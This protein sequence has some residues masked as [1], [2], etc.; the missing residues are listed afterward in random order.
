[1]SV[2]IKF[3]TEL[4]QNYKQAEVVAPEAKFEALQTSEG[5]SLFFSI[6]MDNIFYLTREIVEH[7]TGWERTD[8]SSALSQFHN[9]LPVTAKTFAVSQ[10]N[11]SQNVDIALAVT[12][13]GKDYL[14]LAQNNSNS[15]ISWSSLG[16]NWL[17]MPFDDQNHSY[18][19]IDIVDIYIAQAHN[20][21]YIV[22]DIIKNP[23]DGQKFV[24]RYYIDP[25]KQIT[26]HIWNPHDLPANIEPDQISSC[27]GRRAKERVDGIY[28]FG[29]INNKLELFY[30]P[31]Y[32]PFNPRTPANPVRLGI[33]ASASAIAAASALDE[34]YTDLFIAGNKAL[35]Y[36]PYNQ[37]Q[38]GQNAIKVFENEIFLD[39]QKLFVH[40]TTSKVI[41]W[42]LN[43]AQEIFYT[44]CN[45]TEIQNSSAWSYPLALLNGVE[46][47]ATYV[48]CVND[49]NTF[50]AHVGNNQLKKAVQ[51]P[52]TTIWKYRDILLPPLKA[53][54]TESLR[55]NS[56][57]TRIHIT[58]DKNTPLSGVKIKLGSLDRCS[59]Y[60]NNRYY[61]LDKEPIEITSDSTGGI[62]IVEKVDNLRGSC[63]KIFTD[64]G[65]IISIN[66]M[67]KSR[68]KV[69]QLNSVEKLTN[70]AIE[71]GT[72]GS[73]SKPLISPSTSAA[74]KQAIVD[75]I[76]QIMTVSQSLPDDGSVKS[77]KNAATRATF[78]LSAV[79]QNQVF[80]LAMPSNSSISYVGTD[81]IALH[82][83]SFATSNGFYDFT[84]TI[85]VIAGDIISF[86]ES[87]GKEIFHV[88]VVKAKEAWHFI[89][90]VGEK[91]YR[92]AL[93]CAE[94]VIHGIEIIFKGINTFIGDLINYV[95]FLFNWEDFVRTKDVFKKLFLLYFN[96]VLDDVENLKIDFNK[97][98]TEAKNT[99]DDWAGIK[100]D[101][102]K[103]SVVNS[104]HPLGYLRTITDVGGV[105]TSPGMFLFQHFVDNAPSNKGS[106]NAAI[107][108][109]DDLLNRT[110]QA[111]EDEENV[112]IDAVNRIRSELI[113]NLQYESLSFGDVLT[114]LT[115]IIVDAILYS[116]EDLV[117]L[118]IDVF[119]TIS[120]A[121]VEALDT[122]I[123]I[124]VVS[125]ILEDIGIKISFSMLDVVVMIGAIP[126]TLVYM[127]IKNMA[128]FSSGDGFSDEILAAKDIYS[129][130]A[131]FAGANE[132]GHNS[133]RSVAPY[134]AAMSN[135]MQPLMAMSLALSEDHGKQQ[136][137]LVPINLP[138]VARDSIFL[139]GNLL[140]GVVTLCTSVLSVADALS[141]EGNS[142]FETAV[143]VSAAVGA[144]SAGL[145]TVFA[146][147]YPIQNNV[148]SMLSRTTTGATLLG[149]VTFYFAPKAVAKKRGITDAVDIQSLKTK[150]KKIGTGFD[151]VIALFALVPTCYH[152]YE[153][154][155]YQKSRDCTEAILY[156]TSNVCNYL[157]RV[158]AFV[159]QMDKE[160]DSKVIFVGTMGTLIALCG[161]LQIAESIIEA[162]GG[163]KVQT[164]P[165]LLA[166]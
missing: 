61:V 16:L 17:I 136:S 97:L 23:D 145:S 7:S 132:G 4:M 120:R 131:A 54:D 42:G 79:P 90:K 36:L 49:G 80:P 87:T 127:G 27:L 133:I 22:V 2:K 57:T 147:P 166:L 84:S 141:D 30:T 26:G 29:D 118:L 123:W 38:D 83:D 35:Y 58:D 64:D 73:T 48:N 143:G 125:D 28:T 50:F 70:A 18:S 12:V 102:W 13:D 45:K 129:L 128:P 150:F 63:F 156:E 40:T 88:F 85:E 72:I 144:I 152:F 165:K 19:R 108:V 37:Q 163:L 149:K 159:V 106:S 162:T 124:P 68:K 113:D 33:P 52:E 121:V 32:N 96:H 81:A 24:F 14:Y 92:F 112:V 67:E 65:K 39:V 109:L 161:G 53:Q 93:D 1:M 105:F 114:K 6:G 75:S 117:D 34:N 15:D 103:P 154:S 119:V 3:S 98:I 160:P 74:D 76:K 20:G 59:V 10:S 82:V 164:A 99:I 78:S 101:N 126:A 95:K 130:Q 51:S 9:G 110:I 139:M 138:L 62:T 31:L 140:G 71:Y 104:A 11:S 44:A 111:L 151:A 91:T 8:L 69:E 158:S 89:A 66:P 55:F 77:V 43:R 142:E 153:L 135:K 100:D 146:Q 107:D 41:V 21:E 155:N 137:S 5:H 47:V 25:S 115:G 86:I 134:E 122:P 148:M 157:S 94:K 56:Y 46:Q 116:T 60:I